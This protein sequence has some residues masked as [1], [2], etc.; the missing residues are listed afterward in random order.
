MP[1]THLSPMWKV[2]RTVGIVVVIVVAALFVVSRLPSLN[3]FEDQEVDR[4]QPALLQS[5]K[6]LSQYHAAEGNFQV[7]VDLEH[8]VAWV[9]DVI[10]GSRTLFVSAGT[11]DAYVDLGRLSDEALRVN[12][13]KRTVAVQLPEA[14]LDKPSI[15]QK[16]TYLYSQ[17]RGV[18]DRVSSLFETKDQQEFYVMAE[19]KMAAAAKDAGLTERAEKNTRAMLSGMF[20]SLGYT[21]EFPADNAS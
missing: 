21:A 10:A 6:D 7:V 9:P 15:D 12:T 4:S 5:V 8:D 2:G 13:E 11:V 18:F 20:K 3:P 19:E 14:K 16:R 17:E 1:V